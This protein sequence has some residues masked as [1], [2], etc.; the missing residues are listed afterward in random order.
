MYNYRLNRVITSEP[1]YIC[2]TTFQIMPNSLVAARQKQSVSRIGVHFTTVNE[3]IVLFSFE[4]L[5]KDVLST[6]TNFAHILGRN[7]AS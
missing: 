1:G 5:F 2:A 6:R 4:T 7:N 3:S